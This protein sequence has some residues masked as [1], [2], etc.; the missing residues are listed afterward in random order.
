MRPL[1]F[2]TLTL[3]C[4][5]FSARAATFTVTTTAEVGPGSLTQAILDANA[6][7]GFDQIE[8]A[9]PPFDTTVKTIVLNSSPPPITDPVVVDG[10]TQPNTTTNTA[11][12]GS[13]A[14]LLIRIHDPSGSAVLLV[15]ASN[16]VIRGLIFDG[17]TVQVTAPVDVTLSGNFFGTDPDGLNPGVTAVPFH[18]QILGGENHRI[19]GTQPA[20]R[21]LLANAAEAAILIS[22]AGNNQQILNNCIGTQRDGFSAIGNDGDGIQIFDSVGSLILSNV[23]AH[24]GGAGIVITNSTNQR[25]IGN[26]IFSNGGLGIDLLG[27]SGPDANDPCDPDIGANNLQNFPVLTNATGTATSTT[28]LGVLNSAILSDYVIEFFA[29]SDCDPSGFGEGAVPIGS[30]VVTTDGN[31]AGEFSVTLPVSVTN[32]PI[33]T[34]TATDAA[35]NTS[36]FSE[37]IPVLLNLNADLGVTVTD[38]PDPVVALT[39]LTYSIVVTNFGPNPAGGVTVTNFLPTG[40][41]FNSASPSVGSC[42]N[43][44]SLVQCTLGALPVNTAATITLVATPTVTGIATNVTQVSSS[45]PDPFIGNN[46]FTSLTEVTASGCLSN[47]TSLVAIR[48]GR[49][50]RDYRNGRDYH[51]VAIQ[52]ISAQNIP[53]PIH[54]VLQGL[55]TGVT[56][57]NASGITVCPTFGGLPYR[58]V[59]ST[60]R[61]LP[62]GRRL[63]TVL[64]YRLQ[65]DV[66]P[67]FTP[68]VLSGPGTP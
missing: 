55:P 44:G 63:I 35:G 15:N 21:N 30:V 17:V 62:P 10:Y 38:T 45:Q 52:N 60:T 41:T 66:C 57:L 7:L 23:I 33:I 54:L 1:G 50:H 68:Q 6:N 28:I 39:P 59:R 9:I 20:D 32:A 51:R 19:G 16:S 34:A 24:S 37:C 29:N 2:L 56:L 11:P 22:N 14:N 5:V 36:E 27:Q 25:I 18:V 61:P 48:V 13:N 12:V 26:Q 4:F 43:I 58:T 65:P 49:L 3:W 42:T 67:N 64:E 8:F 40:A 47:V 46:S 53:G 31:C